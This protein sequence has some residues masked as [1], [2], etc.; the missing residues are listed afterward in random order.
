MYCGHE[1]TKKNLE[2]A[3][4]VDPNNDAVKQKLAWAQDQLNVRLFFFSFFFYMSF[5]AHYFYIE[6]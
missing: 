5:N 4:T 3:L 6:R 2:F 1:Y